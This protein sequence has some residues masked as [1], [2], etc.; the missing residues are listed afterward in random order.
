MHDATNG[1]SFSLTDTHNSFWTA[2]IPKY[3]TNGTRRER[4]NGNKT[5]SCLSFHTSHPT[6]TARHTHTQ[7][8][9]NT[10]GSRLLSDLLLRQKQKKNANTEKLI[11]PSSYHPPRH[12]AGNTHTHTHKLKLMEHT[13]PQHVTKRLQTLRQSHNPPAN[14]NRRT[15]P[16]RERRKPSDSDITPQHK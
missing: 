12:A 10:R 9:E 11:L 1:G 16:R 8:H 14:N 13:K 2:T 15:P 6:T 4:P 5:A 7:T 3:K